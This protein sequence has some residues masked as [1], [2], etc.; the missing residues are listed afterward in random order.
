MKLVEYARFLTELDTRNI[1][2]KNARLLAPLQFYSARLGVIVVAPAGFVTDWASI[3]LIVQNPL[4]QK[5]GPWDWGA[6]IHDAAYRLALVDIE[7]KPYRV[8]K[9][10]ADH[11]FLE[12]ME[13]KKV[14]WL[15]RRTYYAAVKYFGHGQFNEKRNSAVEPLL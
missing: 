4:I 3:P 15:R 2:G 14:G 8:T 11:L 13:A 5:R 12:G 10:T 6:V 7:G 1:D 9:D